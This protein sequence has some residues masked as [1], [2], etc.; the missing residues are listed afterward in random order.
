MV[1]RLR[2]TRRAATFAEM[3]IDF[4]ASRGMSEHVAY[5]RATRVTALVGAGEWDEALREAHP[6]GAMCDSRPR[7]IKSM[8]NSKRSS[9]S[10]PKIALAASRTR[11]KRSAGR[12]AK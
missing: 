5:Y 11:G 10:P 1:S 12:E 7:I 9:G 3:G 8:P 6:P 2:T 4:T